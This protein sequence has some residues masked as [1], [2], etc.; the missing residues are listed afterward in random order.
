MSSNNS[1][2]TA[3]H[4]HLIGAKVSITKEVAGE[5]ELGWNDGTIVAAFDTPR[6]VGMHVCNPE[7]GAVTDAITLAAVTLHPDTVKLIVSTGEL[8]SATMAAT[9]KM[10]EDMDGGM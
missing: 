8:V 5:L 7:T 2:A 1:S 4:Q 9:K 6:G 3:P 10:L